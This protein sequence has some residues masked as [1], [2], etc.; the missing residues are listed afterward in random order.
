MELITVCIECK[1]TYD[2]MTGPQ[3][4]CASEHNW[5][6]SMSEKFACAMMALYLKGKDKEKT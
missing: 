6:K 1:K 3:C 5:Y 2:F 4:P